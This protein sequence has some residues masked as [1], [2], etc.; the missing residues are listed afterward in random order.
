MPET[1]S[2]ISGKKEVKAI[3]SRFDATLME[4]WV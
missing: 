4:R 3:R 2:E 1:V